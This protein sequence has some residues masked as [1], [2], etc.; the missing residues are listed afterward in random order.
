MKR[1]AASHR[2]YTHAGCLVLLSSLLLVSHPASA[3]LSSWGYPKSLKE[4]TE[5]MESLGQQLQDL[6]NDRET[7]L[8]SRTEAEENLAKLVFELQEA[9]A[10]LKAKQAPVNRA[11]E[12]YRRAQEIALTDPLID[13]DGPQMEF[14]LVQEESY[15]DIRI[16]QEKVDLIQQQVSQAT[17]RFNMARLEMNNV[18][19]Q[20]E[21][22]WARQ[23]SV[24]KVVFLH[25]VND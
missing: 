4:Q 22:L 13:V 15:E 19:L 10:I 17:E 8:V 1:L 23:E 20:I 6:D 24:G 12:N 9:N 25:T 2:T 3:Q 21:N 16:H 7:L 5:R 11:L 18:L 14:V